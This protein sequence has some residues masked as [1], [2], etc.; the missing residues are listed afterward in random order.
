MQILV[1]ERD[2]FVCCAKCTK[3]IA[4]KR[5]DPID[6]FPAHVTCINR[7]DNY[8]HYKLISGRIKTNLGCVPVFEVITLLGTSTK[9]TA[10]KIIGPI[11]TLSYTCCTCE[12]C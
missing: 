6:L 3:T 2:F 9:T 5:I 12:L 10:V 4:V 11:D 8:S 7:N 1:F